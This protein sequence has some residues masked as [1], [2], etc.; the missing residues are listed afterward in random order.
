MMFIGE[1]LCLIAFGVQHLYKKHQRT[2]HQALTDPGLPE[3]QVIRFNPFIFAIPALCDTTATTMMYIGLL[4]VSFYFRATVFKVDNTKTKTYASV[5][6]MIRGAVVVFTAIFSV[7]FLKKR[8]RFFF[9][10]FSPSSF[11]R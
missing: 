11:L 9:F 6:Q 4:L 3:P 10:F 5:Y 2:K 1:F 8:V 7:L